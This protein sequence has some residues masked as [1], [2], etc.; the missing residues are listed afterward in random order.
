VDETE[1]HHNQDQ[2]AKYYMFLLI[3]IIRMKIMAMRIIMMRHEWKTGTLCG[4]L[5]IGRSGNLSR[6][7]PDV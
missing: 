3:G 7:N 6:R 2:K 1:D 4:G 5:L